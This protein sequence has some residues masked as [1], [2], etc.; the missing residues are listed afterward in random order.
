MMLSGINLFDIF[1][2][3]PEESPKSIEEVPDL[4]LKCIKTGN[5]ET[6]EFLENWLLNIHYQIE[7]EWKEYDYPT[8]R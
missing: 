8:K 1:A 2:Q 7:A 6:A 5:M 4:I 3:Y